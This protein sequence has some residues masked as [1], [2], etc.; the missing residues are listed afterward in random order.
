MTKGNVVKRGIW[1]RIFG[2]CNSLV[3]VNNSRENIG[4]QIVYGDFGSG[5]NESREVF[6]RDNVQDRFTIGSGYSSGPTINA[7]KCTI[8]FMSGR[9]TFLRVFETKRDKMFTV[10][11]NDFD[12]D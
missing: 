3:I 1:E 10:M 9:G 7:K 11:R 5:E 2:C 6:S 8:N 12:A 4:V